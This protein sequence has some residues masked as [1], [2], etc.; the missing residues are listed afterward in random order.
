MA[1][2]KKK[3][4]FSPEREK[5]HEIIFEADTPAGRWFDIALLYFI[6]GSVAIVLLESVNWIG[7]KFSMTF[8][9][10]EWIFTIF[11]TAEYLLRIYCVYE[12]KK[13]MTSFFGIIDLLAILPTFLEILFAGTHYLVVVRSLRILR[14]FRIL[15]LASLLKESSVIIK[16]LKA[17]VP[18]ITVFIIFV[19]ILVT[20]LG[21]V[22]Y[23]IEGG[24]ENT[25][26]DS[27]PRSIYWAI[28]TLTT[29]GYEDISPVS[30]FG[31]FVAAI[32]MLLGYAVI[33]VPTGIVSVELS[34][35]DS[36][37]LATNTQACRFCS[38]EG[39]ADDAI[40]C[41][42]CGNPIHPNESPINEKEP[43]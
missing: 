13:Y 8:F 24:Y 34:K 16:A 18:K 3:Y 4:N 1:G 40:Y 5:I 2:T 28:V 20:I 29:V 12:P 33:A 7:E 27:I 6:L 32:V 10:L 37:D 38:Q 26:F 15:K 14:V 39:H 41:K 17:S 43:T 23:V 35:Q 11:F 19:L 31:Q 25:S 36:D 42:Y 22:M 9:I 21:S 30:A